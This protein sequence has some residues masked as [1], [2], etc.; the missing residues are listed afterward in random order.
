MVLNGRAYHDR[1]FATGSLD[2][3]GVRSW[4]WG[5]MALP[6]RE[7]VFGVLWPTAKAPTAEPS[8]IGMEIDAHGRMQLCEGLTL[9]LPHHPRPFLGVRPATMACP[10]AQWPCIELHERLSPVPASE[11]PSPAKQAVW[12]RAEMRHRLDAGPD[13]A[14]FFTHGTADEG[15]LIGTMAGHGT[16]EITA[17]PTGAGQTEA[18]A[19][20]A[21]V[22]TAGWPAVVADFHR[23]RIAQLAEQI[24]WPI[25]APSL[26]APTANASDSDSDSADELVDGADELGHTNGHFP[27]G[28]H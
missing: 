23:A 14:R 13:S 12:L 6:K 21:S 15:Q 16:C 24:I 5:H 8:V 11:A 25:A 28:P 4:W 20:P 26:H 3:L 18:K 17:S 7:R 19:C 2:T 1:R 27:H 10:S 9:H 22:G